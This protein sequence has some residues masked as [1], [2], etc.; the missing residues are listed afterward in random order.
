V[1]AGALAFFAGL[2]A[3]YAGGSAALDRTLDV[4]PMLVPTLCAIGLGL[5]ASGWFAVRSGRTKQALGNAVFAGAGL[6]FLVFTLAL[7]LNRYADS[8]LGREAS[9][10][11]TGYKTSSKGPR[12]AKLRGTGGELPTS[13]A[14]QAASLEGCAQGDLAKL[15]V[16]PGALGLAWVSKVTCR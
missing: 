16:R 7:S 1:R 3:W 2:V 10:T 14:I 12:M 13:F 6:G 5:G 4:A 8:G 15:E 11:V 9:A